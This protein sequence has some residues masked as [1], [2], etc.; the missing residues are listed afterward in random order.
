M[1]HRPR[2]FGL[3]AISPLFVMASL[4]VALSFVAGELSKVPILIVFLLTAVYT[5]FITRGIPL[6]QRITHFSKGA[7][8]PDLVLMLWIFILAGMFATTAKAMGAIEAT[9]NLTLSI[10]PSTMLVPSLFVAACFISMSIGTSVG[11]IVALSPIAMGLAD[12][13]DL[14]L[15]LIAGAVVSGA[16]FGDNLSFISDTT[17]AATRTQGCVQRDKFRVNIRIAL[18]AAIIATIIYGIIGQNV[19]PTL[20]LESIEWLKILPY[21]IVIATALAGIN[22]LVVLSIGILATGIIGLSTDTLT[23][24]A[25]LTSSTEGIMGMAELCLISMLAGG[26]MELIRYNGGIIYLIHLLTRRVSGRRGA[27]LSIATL[28]G[29]TN[30]CTANNTVAILSV[31]RLA[32]DI[33]TKYGVDKRR[34]ASILDTISCCVQGV[35]P[36]GAQLLIVSGITGLNPFDLIPYLFYPFILF[37]TTLLAI[38]LPRKGV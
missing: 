31:G 23:A 20:V 30:L 10:L 15:P 38:L 21:L 18:P 37:V 7:G 2:R 9:V 19:R 27:E 8:S 34:S 11:T 16:F 32:N 4:F 17:I 33:S 28:V 25:W 22:V 12:Q 14:P 35:I 1:R 5:L 6:T 24:A 36:Y 3:L 29:L 13:I 26:L